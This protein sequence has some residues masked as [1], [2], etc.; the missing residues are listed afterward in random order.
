M[1]HGDENEHS[2]VTGRYGNR[3]MTQAKWVATLARSITCSRRVVVVSLSLR[4]IPLSAASKE[5]KQAKGI[6]GALLGPTERARDSA[7]TPKSSP[8]KRQTNGIIPGIIIDVGNASLN[9]LIQSTSPTW[10]DQVGAICDNRAL[11]PHAT[12]WY[13]SIADTD[14]IKPIG[15]R[16]RKVHGEYSKASQA[17]DE[18]YYPDTPTGSNGG[19]RSLHYAARVSKL[20][21]ERLKRSC[22]EEMDVAAR[23]GIVRDERRRRRA[24]KNTEAR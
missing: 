5:N 19:D 7:K 20:S 11:S 10:F 24:E 15:K 4:G 3:I 2:F 18:G 21:S 1:R 17:L 6:L 16:A 22:A 9:R 12:P 14:S 23:R 8:R 13:F